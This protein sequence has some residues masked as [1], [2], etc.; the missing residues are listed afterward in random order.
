MLRYFSVVVAFLVLCA[1]CHQSAAPVNLADPIESGRGFIEA[2]LKGNYDEAKKY[3]LQDSMNLDLLNR[4]KD[5][6]KTRTKEEK[7]GYKNANIIINKADN[8][9]DSET[10]IDYTNTYKNMPSKVKLKKVGNEWRV[11]FKYTISGNL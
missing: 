8:V 2:S 11:D 1:S 3:I 9:S 10:V 5:F 4:L 7:E 6:Y